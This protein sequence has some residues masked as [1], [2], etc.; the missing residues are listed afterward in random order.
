[1]RN[2][3]L[4][5]FQPVS[6]SQEKSGVKVAVIQS[7]TEPSQFEKPLRIT[8]NKAGVQKAREMVLEILNEHDRIVSGIHYIHINK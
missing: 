8:G 2:Y 7:S 3:S 6:I 1:M 4:S 5:L